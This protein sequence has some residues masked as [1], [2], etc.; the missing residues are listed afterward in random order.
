MT[1]VNHELS[2]GRKVLVMLALIFATLVPMG[3]MV[4]I[5]AAESMYGHFSDTSM[6][7]LNFILSGPALIGIFVAPIVG[8]LM[9]IMRK[10]TLLIIGVVIFTIGAVFGIAIENAVYMAVMRAIVGV[11]VGIVAPVCMA[12][13]ADI[14]HDEKQLGSMIGIWNAGMSGIGAVLS[15]VAG[16]VATIQWE[17]VFRI[18]LIALPILIMIFIF[19][20]RKTPL[21]TDRGAHDAEEQ[22]HRSVSENQKMPWGPVLFDLVLYC[23]GAMIICVM[24]YQISMYVVE[25]AI[26]NAAVAGI[27]S[28]VLTIGTF[29]AC[30]TFGPL[31]GKCKQY[32]P[33]IIFACIAITYA[34]FA[35]VP[36]L[37]GAGIAMALDGIANGLIMSYYQTH[38]AVIVPEKQVPFA[39]SLS[40]AFL[41]LG[42]FLTTYLTTFLQSIGN[43][44]MI[45]VSLILAIGSLVLLIINAFHSFGK[46]KNA[47]NK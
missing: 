45:Q 44:T 42:M 34:L 5:P 33:I 14:F 23:L 22:Q 46:R 29:V 43:G 37:V 25:T 12:I 39:L 24:Y 26:G 27:L 10:K 47:V 6:G 2:N 1:D 30:V 17:Y 15:I 35:F 18:Y 20:P 8:K 28:T 4:I 3:D 32:L 19:L 16:I 41:G 38:L 11:A 40:S 13:M 36:N 21:E 7:V 9:A 31:Y